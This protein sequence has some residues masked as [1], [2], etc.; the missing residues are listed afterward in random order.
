MT[1]NQGAGKEETIIDGQEK[2]GPE[3]PDTINEALSSKSILN[4]DDI[5]EEYLE[6]V[7]QGKLRRYDVYAIGLKLRGLGL[8]KSGLSE[9]VVEKMLPK[10]IDIFKLP[11]TIKDEQTGVDMPSIGVKKALILLIN[12]YKLVNKS[13]FSESALTL[14]KEFGSNL[15]SA[16]KQTFPTL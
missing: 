9:Q 8:T 2:Q 3:N 12:V 14:K 4:M 6:F 7:F 13:S 1:E 11:K 15:P 5:K 10:I 16:N